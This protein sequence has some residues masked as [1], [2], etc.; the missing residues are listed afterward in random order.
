M[1]ATRAWADHFPDGKQILHVEHT[2]PV[3]KTQG[4]GRPIHLNFPGIFMR[5]YNAPASPFFCLF[6]NN[7]KS[8]TDFFFY[9]RLVVTAKRCSSG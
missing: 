9:E 8:D 5:F 2:P 1:P 7:P 3:R 4:K 6:L